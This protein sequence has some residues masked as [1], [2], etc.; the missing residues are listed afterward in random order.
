MNDELLAT[1]AFLVQ[2]G[3]CLVSHHGFINF[4]AIVLSYVKR[5]QVCSAPAGRKVIST[6]LAVPLAI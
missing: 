3:T 6:T 5:T 1:S 4:F 2:S